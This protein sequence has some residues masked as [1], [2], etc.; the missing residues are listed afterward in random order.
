MNL[1]PW[2]GIG[3]PQPREIG[4]FPGEYL[5]VVVLQKGK[6]RAILTGRKT[7]EQGKE[8]GMVVDNDKAMTFPPPR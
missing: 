8:Y 5:V 6:D 2:S 7:F 1:K 4:V 3:T